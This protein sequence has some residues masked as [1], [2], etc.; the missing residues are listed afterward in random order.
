[1]NEYLISLYYILFGIIGASFH[2]IKK[3]YV[4]ETTNLTFKEYLFTNKRATFNTIFAIVSTEV[5]LSILHSGGDFLSLS[6]F[7]GALTAGYTADSGV[8]STKEEG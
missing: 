2:Y 8:N 3:R 5:G 4:D 7:V 1:M 6:E